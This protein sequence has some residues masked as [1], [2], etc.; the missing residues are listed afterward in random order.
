MT[1]AQINK[2]KT[3]VPGQYL[4]Y[5]L[6][7]VR[8]CFHLLDAPL[9]AQVSM[10]HLDDVA[11]HYADGTHLL[12]QTKSALSGNPASDRSVEL[13]KAMANWADL[14]V[15]NT[16]SPQS[17]RFRYYV[18]PSAGGA[19]VKRLHS[20]HDKTAV[21][22]LLK[23]IASAKIKGKPESTAYPHIA[24]FLAAGDEIFQ[25]IGDEVV[26]A[27]GNLQVIILDHAGLDV[28]GEIPGV[29]LTEEWRDNDALVPLHWLTRR[30]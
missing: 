12:E 1:V 22:D 15:A 2:P 6:Q 16:V 7:P 23:E 9:D 25:A 17:T 14:C 3:S 29:V 5:A 28:W 13:W 4:G 27:K 19:L 10:E 20:A 8:L 26:A 21:V 24:R 11:V 30:S 18:T